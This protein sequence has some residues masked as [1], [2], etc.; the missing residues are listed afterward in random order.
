M[1]FDTGNVLILVLGTIWLIHN[2]S[3]TIYARQVEK[4]K[5]NI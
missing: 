1:I 4:G 5:I 2:L 3:Y